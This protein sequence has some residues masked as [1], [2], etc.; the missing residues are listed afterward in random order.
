MDALLDYL[1]DIEEVLESSKSLPFTNKISVEKERVL[2]ILNE[3]RLNLP[4][5]IRSAQRILGDHDRI[6][7]EAERKSQAIL[8]SAENE[9]KIRTN[10]HEIFRRASDQASET[11]EE[12]KR[13]AR[14]LRLNAMDYADSMLKDAEDQVKEYMSNIEE[15]HKKVMDYFN[16]LI[17]VIYEN[18]QQLRGR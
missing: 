8:E 3:I 7:A 2:D 13:N 18:R 16:Q 9:A 5:D 10:N 11:V 17:D 14:D 12:A 1:D 4:D 15:Q 6:V